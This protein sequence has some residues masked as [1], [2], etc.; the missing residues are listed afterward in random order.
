MNLWKM[1]TDDATNIGPVLLDEELSRAVRRCGWKPN[2]VRETLRGSCVASIEMGIAKLRSSHLELA[3]IKLPDFLIWI[4][5]PIVSLEGARVMIGLGCDSKEFWPC[6]FQTNP[7]EQYFFHLPLRSYDIVDYEKSEF[8]Q[9]LAFPGKDAIPMFAKNICFN[10]PTDKLPPCFRV[11]IPKINQ[12]L[13]DLFVNDE[14]RSVWIERHLSGAQF[15]L[16]TE[17]A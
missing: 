17:P 12:T 7:D 11:S 10:A 16:L 3:A 13:I 1:T 9:S 15:T 4:W 8:L 14:F 5:I 6:R 2:L